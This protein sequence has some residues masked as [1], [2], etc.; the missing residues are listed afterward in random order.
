M[1][2]SEDIMKTCLKIKRL[3]GYI[4]GYIH[5]V[6]E[7]D[8]MKNPDKIYHVIKCDP[9]YRD[10]LGRWRMAVEGNRIS[11]PSSL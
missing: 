4:F 9:D 1:M 2:L 3:S 7:K 6:N 8:S 5:Y 10:I 11:A